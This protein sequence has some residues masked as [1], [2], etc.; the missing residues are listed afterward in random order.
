MNISLT[1]E[2]ENLIQ[3]RIAT[4]MYTNASEVVRDALRHF[5]ESDPYKPLRE[6]MLPRIASAERGEVTDKSFDEII[7]E[8]KQEKYVQ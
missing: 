4:G 1:P 2:F 7:G 3:Q 5:E 8:A 6:V